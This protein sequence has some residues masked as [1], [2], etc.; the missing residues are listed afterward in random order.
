MFPSSMFDPLQLSRL[1]E[2]Q[3]ATRPEHIRR[4]FDLAS[5]LQKVPTGLTPKEVIWTKNKAL[6]YHYLPQA[7]QRHKTPLLL[8][9]ALI[10]KPYI[11]DLYP[12]N[13][14][15][16]HMVK[17]G[18]EVYLL[19][20]GQWGPEDRDVS[21]DSLV[22]DYI[23]GAVRKVIR[24]SGQDRLSI[25]GYCIGGIL[26]TIYTA[27][28]PQAPLRNAIFMAAPVDFAQAGLFGNWLDPRHF[29]LEQ[30]LA[31]YGNMPGELIEMGAKML[32][33]ITNYVTPFVNLGQ[34]LDDEKYLQGWAAMNQWVN[35]RV[36]FPGAAF[37]Q[38]VKDLYQE[39][40]L[41]GGELLIDGRRVAHDPTVVGA[42]LQHRKGEAAHPGWPCG[43]GR[44]SRR[45]K[46][47]LAEGEHVARGALRLSGSAVG[48]LGQGHRLK[49]DGCATCC[50]GWTS[51]NKRTPS[52]CSSSRFERD[53]TV[54]YRLR[55]R[56]APAKLGLRA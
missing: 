55:R 2:Q 44:R 35:D 17:Q 28:H 48:R 31:T 8:I 22:L 1:F 49:V 6:L 25:M 46:R 40:K 54:S 38:L 52:A 12:G 37:R 36:D 9:Y 4:G 3:Y 11:L 20:W 32:K 41:I 26:T 27:L 30:V 15:V 45:D 47:S 42:H 43:P 53:I 24:H 14:F 56:V 23:P 18:F 50:G 51:I 10:N 34:R 7:E 13:S 39:N 29:P 16:E 5:G 33:P 21:L 19:D